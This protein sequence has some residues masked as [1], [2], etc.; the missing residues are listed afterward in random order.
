MPRRQRR[1]WRIA[2]PSERAPEVSE[3]EARIMPKIEFVDGADREFV[4]A[5]DRAVD[6]PAIADRLAHLAPEVAHMATFVH[7]RGG[8]DAPELF[9]VRVPP[10]TRIDPHAHEDDE[11]VV[12]AEGSLV[13]GNRT[14]GPGSSVFVP[15]LTLY[16]FRAGPDGATFLNF[17]PRSAPGAITKSELVTRLAERRASASADTSD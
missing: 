3:K 1:S 7:H 8:P 14:Y 12:V 2:A 5:A 9:E 10:G 17:R 6:D 11:I 4:S 15:G 16:S 13:F